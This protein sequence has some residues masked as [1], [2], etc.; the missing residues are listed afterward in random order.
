MDLKGIVVMIDRH[1]TP[2]EDNII[3]QLYEQWGSKWAAIRE[4]RSMND[5]FFSNSSYSSNCQI[6]LRTILKVAGNH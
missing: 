4:V 1:W 2:E 6:E 3:L 5:L